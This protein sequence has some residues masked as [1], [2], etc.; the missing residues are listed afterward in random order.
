MFSYK[1]VVGAFSAA[2]LLGSSAFAA[3]TDGA[4]VPG[5][6][7]GVNKAQTETG[8]IILGAAGIGLLAGVAIIVADQSG[9]NPDK[10]NFASSTSTGA[11]G[12]GGV[13][14]GHC[15]HVAC[16]QC[17]GILGVSHGASGGDGGHG[18]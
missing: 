10:Q 6:P 16:P 7:A 18:A 4:L 1:S 11:G 13:L 12:F 8:A 5:K 9:K 3:S 2:V 14:A 17:H 15:R